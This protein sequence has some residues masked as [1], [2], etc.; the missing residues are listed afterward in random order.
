MQITRSKIHYLPTTILV[1]VGVLG[2]VLSCDDV[3]A[4]PTYADSAHGNASYGVNRSDVLPD[5]DHPD[6]YDIGACAHCH[7]LFD[8]STC[9]QYNFMLF[10]DDV[11]SISNLFCFTC[12]SGSSTWQQVTNYPYCIN[13]GGQASLFYENIWEQFNN[14]GSMYNECGSRHHLGQIYNSLKSSIGQNWGFSSDPDPCVACHNPH[15][16]QR[17]HPVAIGGEGK[18]NT[19]IRRPS[20]YKSTNPQDLLWGDDTDERMKYSAQNIYGGTYQAPYYGDTAGTK[21]EPSGNANPSDGSDLPD[22]VTFCL[23]CHQYELW[24]PEREESVKAIDWTG[25]RHG[26]YPAN[27]CVGR[28]GE[29]SLRAPYINSAN[30]NYVLSC[31]D[32]HEPHGTDRRR[33]LLRRFI[34]GEPTDTAECSGADMISICG[35]CHSSSFGHGTGAPFGYA[36]LVCH[37]HGAPLWGTGCPE[38]SCCD[39][40]MF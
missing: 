33:H 4:A 8:D 10:Y 5:P 27:D 1:F 7:A 35:R 11:I 6:A 14:S 30:S 13:F 18:L 20:H 16:D 28:Y 32:C 36:C 12:H 34:N 17:N 24:D 26:A 9:G 19:A 23:D 25:A 15:A 2:W 40:P 39:K 3:V 31:L 21:F 29:G 37:G 38:T 22:Y